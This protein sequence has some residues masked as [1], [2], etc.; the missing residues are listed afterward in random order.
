MFIEFL[1]TISDV[2]GI[3]GVVI[4]LI[5]YYL[6][7]VGKMSA[8]SMSYQ[9]FNLLGAAFILFSLCFH[10]NTSSV[11]IEIAWIIISIIGIYN[12]TRARKAAT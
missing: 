8:L 11:L 6:L 10:W 9:W 5:A 12:A 2:V 3:S 1:S 4:L 7:N